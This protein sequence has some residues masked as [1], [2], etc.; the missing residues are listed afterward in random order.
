MNSTDVVEIKALV[1]QSSMYTSETRSVLINGHT[2]VT[3]WCWS[4]TAL[5]KFAFSLL[6]NKEWSNYYEIIIQRGKVSLNPYTMNVL[7]HYT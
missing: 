1:A 7:T 4:S 3:Q 2:L 6:C 5:E